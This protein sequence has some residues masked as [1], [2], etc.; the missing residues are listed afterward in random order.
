MDA[1]KDVE[2]KEKVLSAE[3]R[4]GNTHSEGRE[5]GVEGGREEGWEEGRREGKTDCTARKEKGEALR[6][7]GLK[8][9]VQGGRRGGKEGR[10]EVCC[11]T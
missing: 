6:K 5:A 10:R 1:R 9:K 4:E 2:S 8:E 11:A 3:R 7:E